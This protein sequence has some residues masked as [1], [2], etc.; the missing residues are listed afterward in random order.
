[1]Y[2]IRMIDH[3]TLEICEQFGYATIEDAVADIPN[4]IRAWEVNSEDC[5]I[6]V[7]TMAEEDY[8][9]LPKK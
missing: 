2:K 5:E 1:M 8:A 3:V 7:M 4:K 6:L 9:Y